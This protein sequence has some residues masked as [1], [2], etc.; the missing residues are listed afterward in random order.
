MARVLTGQS[1]GLV[2]SGGAARAYAHIGAI[3]ALREAKVPIDFV[4]GSSMGAIIAAGLAMGWDDAELD[5]RI[6]KAFVESSPLADIAFPLIAMTHGAQVHARMKEHFGEVQIAD[7]W[8]PFFCVSSDLTSGTYRLHRRGLVR[9]ALEASIALP[10]I[11]PPVVDKGHVLVDGAVTKN[12]PSDI[13]R[14][15]QAGP[16]VGVDV[17]HARGLKPEDIKTPVSLWRWILSGDWKR[18]PPIVSVLMRSATLS[19]GRDLLVGREST[20]VLIT[21]EVSDIEIRNWKAYDPAVEAGYRAAR[22]ALAR[23]KAPVTAL[24]RRPTRSERRRLTAA[25]Q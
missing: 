15:I 14:T 16:I 20:D 2:L 12:F 7:L 9:E 10:G 3:R 6:R 13:M 22:E 18:G 1:V 5:A 11:L 4:G 8:L 17:T 21:P 25:A 23:L 19:T 24:R